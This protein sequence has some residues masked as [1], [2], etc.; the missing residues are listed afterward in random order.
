MNAPVACASDSPTVTT[1]IAGVTATDNCGGTVAI[2]HVGDVISNQSCPNRYSIART[3]RATALCGNVTDRIQ[4][5]TVNDQTGPTITTFPTDVNVPCA[6]N[7][8][9]GATDIPGITATD[10]CGGTVHITQH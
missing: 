10:R 7:V 8:P 5:I 9:A 1:D 6:S 2:S 3:Y 4:T